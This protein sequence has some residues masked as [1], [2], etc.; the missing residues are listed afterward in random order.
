MEVLTLQQLLTPW[1]PQPKLF[2]HPSKEVEALGKE[3][4]GCWQG[5]LLI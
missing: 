2:E 3:R 5:H 4:G 1:S